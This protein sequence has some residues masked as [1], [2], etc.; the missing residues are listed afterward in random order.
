MLCDA[1][2]H[3]VLALGHCSVPRKEM[4]ISTRQSAGERCTARAPRCG[5]TMHISVNTFVPNRAK[6][7]A[8][9]L[10]RRATIINASA[11]RPCQDG[12]LPPH[13]THMLCTKTTFLRVH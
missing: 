1:C 12:T 11:H 4:Y 9:G 7:V 2:R 8:P 13:D 5:E 6:M 3:G 10:S